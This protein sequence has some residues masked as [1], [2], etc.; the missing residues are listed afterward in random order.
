MKNTLL[1]HILCT[2]SPALFLL[3]VILL[4]R[5][6]TTKKK[7][8][9][10]AT[11]R[12]I[13][14]ILSAVLGV[15]LYFLGIYL[16]VF[17]IRDFYMPRPWCL[18]GLAVVIVVF[19]LILFNGIKNRSTQRKLDKAAKAAEAEKEAAVREAVRETQSAGVAAAEAAAAEAR[20]EIARQTAE[21]EAQ[22][23]VGQEEPISLT[24]EPKDP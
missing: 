22:A 5:H 21:A 1:N 10:R 11:M 3:A 18:L 17:T 16:N 8:P 12:L 19:A 14:S 2:Q 7:Q 24:L 4:I 20:L 23:A 13:F 9:V 15:G 6:F